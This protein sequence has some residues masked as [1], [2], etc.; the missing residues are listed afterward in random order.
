MTLY[1][2]KFAALAFAAA[3]VT[4]AA[5]L[6]S[7]GAPAAAAEP[8]ARSAPART[9]AV[10]YTDLNLRSAEGMSRLE[11]RVRNAAERVCAD[12]DT[13]SPVAALA[14]RKCVDAAIAA[15][16]PQVR[17]AIIEQRQ[18]QF[19]ARALTD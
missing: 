2:G 8:A 3:L 11:V 7:T 1:Q 5:T 9:A 10:A 18:E 19:A 4:T 16:A 12:G 17:R 6:V 15:A 14:A 13:Q